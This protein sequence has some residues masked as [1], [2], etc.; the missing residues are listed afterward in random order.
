M[1]AYRCYREETGDYWT[2]ERL[3][4]LHWEFLY[5]HVSQCSQKPVWE[6][7]GI[8]RDALSR[9][10]D[11]MSH[12]RRNKR[13]LEV[14]V[15]RARLCKEIGIAEESVPEEQLAQFFHRHER[16]ARLPLEYPG[17]RVLKDSMASD[18]VGAYRA[19][20]QVEDADRLQ[21]AKRTETVD[22][23]CYELAVKVAQHH[24]LVVWPYAAGAACA[25]VAF[26]MLVGK[27]V[28]ES[29][30]WLGSR[31]SSVQRT[32]SDK[33]L[34]VDFQF[35]VRYGSWSC[36]K[37]FG[38]RHFHDDDG[39]KELCGGQALSEGL[40]RQVPSDPVEHCQGSVGIF[41]RWWYDAKM[42][43][44]DLW[45]HR[46]RQPPA[47]HWTRRLESWKKTRP[48]SETQHL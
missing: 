38:G 28:F 44:P 40:S 46:C 13:D 29:Q 4:R 10:R 22:G 3:A 23:I 19:V 2:E 41:S 11:F 48:V 36:C 24:Q 16:Y 45:C 17:A 42:Y 35:W 14:R 8:K 33:Y 37:H 5:A 32:F 21:S 34:P 47:D 43:K 25:E 20:F 27:R 12:S 1:L 31:L 6:S 9:G 18:A 26:A 7:L 15:V 30:C 39:F